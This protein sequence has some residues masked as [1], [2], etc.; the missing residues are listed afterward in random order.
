M[1]QTRSA[2]PSFFVSLRF[3]PVAPWS[4]SLST[5]TIRFTQDDASKQRDESVYTPPPASGDIDSAA[6]TSTQEHEAADQAGQEGDSVPLT[7][8]TIAEAGSCTVG[9]PSTEA[10]LKPTPVVL[11]TGPFGGNWCFRDTWQASLADQGYQSTSIELAMPSTPL[12]SGDAYVRHFVKLLKRSIETDHSFFPPILIA[13]GFH[14]LVAEKYVESNPVSALVLV[15]PFIPS[16]VKDRLLDLAA[17]ALEEDKAG[18]VSDGKRTD[19]DDT[20]GS[21]DDSPESPLREAVAAS[22]SGTLTAATALGLQHIRTHADLLRI[23]GFKSKYVLPAKAVYKVDR[24]AKEVEEKE[25]EVEREKDKENEEARERS[26][27]PASADANNT[28]QL[29]HDSVPVME[30]GDIMDSASGANTIQPPPEQTV[31]SEASMPSPLEQLPLSI[32]D[33]IPTSIYEPMFPILL[34]TSQGDSIV[35]T[36]DVEQNHHLAGDVDHIALEDDDQ[37]GHMIMVSDNPQWEDGIMGITE[38][39]D[40][41][42]I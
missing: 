18:D 32:Y 1:P 37:G 38:W 31:E 9:P 39:L 35:S 41:N 16:V 6:S 28:E 22:A 11:L 10:F 42:G 5:T 8:D 36:S 23:P 34:L 19:K 30:K 20:K 4:A 2:P 3:T 29:G 17:T 26:V 40:T 12:D 27:E 33:T 15:S 21:M 13:H 7:S 14:A 25:K 24:I